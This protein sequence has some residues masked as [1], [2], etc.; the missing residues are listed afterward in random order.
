MEGNMI[1]I[2][3]ALP[4]ESCFFGCHCMKTLPSLL[5]IFIFFDSDTGTGSAPPLPER[6]GHMAPLKTHIAKTTIRLSSTMCLF[7]T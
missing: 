5:D 1:P 2:G 6:A 3:Q 4:G 7:C